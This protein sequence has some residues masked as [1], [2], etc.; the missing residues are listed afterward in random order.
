MQHWQGG[1]VVIEPLNLCFDLYFK[2]D[3]IGRIEIKNNKL[4][5]NE[6]YTDQLILRPYARVKDA[7]TMVQLLKERVMCEERWDTK[8]LNHIG[9][10]EYNFFKILK[11]TH[12]VDIDDFFWLKFDGEDISYDDVKVRD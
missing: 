5:K 8:Q 7:F 10:T 4:V 1:A 2:Y 9:L 12:G 6:T 3:K 11:I